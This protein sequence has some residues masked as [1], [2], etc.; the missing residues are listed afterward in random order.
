MPRL[1][2]IEA[3]KEIQK[4][5]LKQNMIFVA[6]T[7][8]VTDNTVK[9]CFSIGMDAFI[10]KPIDIKN[11]ANIIKTFINKQIRCN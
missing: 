5:K 9:E 8:T 1:N 2:G 6:I 4:K 11:L 7:A 10:P 3:T